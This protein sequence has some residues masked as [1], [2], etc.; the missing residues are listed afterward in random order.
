VWVGVGVSVSWHSYDAALPPIAPAQ[1]FAHFLHT[2]CLSCLP[3]CL[4]SL[5]E[6]Y[7]GVG[8]MNMD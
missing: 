4:A 3:A 1:A 6:M 8:P 2:A 5:P 7:N